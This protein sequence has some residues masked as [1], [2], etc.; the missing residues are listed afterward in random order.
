MSLRLSEFVQEI[1]VLQMPNK[2]DLELRLLG[3]YFTLTFSLTNTETHTHPHSH[4]V[5]Q[6]L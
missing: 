3:T 1:F 4:T 2:A 6:T 5:T